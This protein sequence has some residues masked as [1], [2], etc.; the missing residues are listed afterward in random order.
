MS[1]A[2]ALTDLQDLTERL[3]RVDFGHAQYQITFDDPETLTRPLTL[4]MAVNYRPDP[5]MLENVLV[6]LRRREPH[7]HKTRYINPATREYGYFQ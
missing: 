4:S 5:D 1:L 2:Q 7:E 3:R 6:R